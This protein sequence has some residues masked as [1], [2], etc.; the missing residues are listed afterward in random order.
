MILLDVWNTED[1]SN[2]CEFPFPDKET[3]SF[4]TSTE[5]EL[6]NKNEHGHF[7]FHCKNKNKLKSFQIIAIFIYP[8]LK[9]HSFPLQYFLL[10]DIHNKDIKMP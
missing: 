1:S 2:I 3:N 8:K 9:A 7:T 6:L 4:S 5:Q 10:T